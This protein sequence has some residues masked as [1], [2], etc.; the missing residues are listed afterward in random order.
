MH[1]RT[2]GST[3]LRLSAV[4]FGVWTVS[5]SWWGISDEQRGI[6]LLREA[7]ELVDMEC[8]WHYRD[9]RDMR[10]IVG[11]AD[12]WDIT[13]NIEFE[14]TRHHALNDAV[15]QAQVVCDLYSQLRRAR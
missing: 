14:G 11:L 13:S 4:G 6:D 10:T 5:T 2:L 7:Y 15:Y 12:T 1:Y 9:D 8:P 3:D